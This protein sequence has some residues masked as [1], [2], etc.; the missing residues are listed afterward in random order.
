[1]S[2]TGSIES[3]RM[4]LGVGYIDGLDRRL[5][6]LS[7]IRTQYISIR[8]HRSKA[9][10]HAKFSYCKARILLFIARTHSSLHLI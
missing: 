1:M 3:S 5:V 6:V 8:L 7:F 10:N 2:D 9:L 4:G